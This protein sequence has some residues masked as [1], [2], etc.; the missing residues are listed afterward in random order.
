MVFPPLISSD[1]FLSWISVVSALSRQLHGDFWA[2]YFEPFLCVKKAVFRRWIWFYQFFSFVW[3][4][5][6]FNLEFS[7]LTFCSFCSLI[8]KVC[9]MPGKWDFERNL[10]WKFSEDLSMY[11]QE[12]KGW[13]T[14][15]AAEAIS[16]LLKLLLV[17]IVCSAVASFTPL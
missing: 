4:L 11:L 8:S 7:V 6:Y 10:W 3:L 5:I 1:F 15:S 14:V 12:K 9:S 13:C 17:C 16:L 2:C